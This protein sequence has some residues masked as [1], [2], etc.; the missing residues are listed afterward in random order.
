MMSRW[1][2]NW[3]TRKMTLMLRSDAW[4]CKN[5]SVVSVAYCLKGCAVAQTVSPSLWTYAVPGSRPGQV[6]CDM[7]W[8]MPP[9]GLFSPCTTVSPT[10]HF[11]DSSTLITIHHPGLLHLAEYWPTCLVGCP[12]PPQE[13]ICCLHLEGA[14]L[15]KLW[16]DYRSRERRY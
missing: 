16:H 10:T 14:N 2:I 1:K 6:M 15:I 9:F 7:W 12:T 4:V 5:W 13:V 8:T 11:T 3:I